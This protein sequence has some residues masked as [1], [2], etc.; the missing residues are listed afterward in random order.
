MNRQT[1]KQLKT[2]EFA[3]ELGQ[4]FSFLKEHRTESI[5]YGLIGL[6]VIVLGAGY[7]FYSR[8]E[9]VVR[10]DAL[11][12]AMKIDDAIVGPADTATNKAFPTK[13]A[14]VQARAKALNDMAT[15]YRGT[16]EGAIAAIFLAADQ[17]D[18]GNYAA[19]EKAYKDVVDSAPK[20]YA[21]LAEVSLADVYSVEGKTEDA[22][23][24]LRYRIDHPTELV[25]S[26]AAKLELA[27]VLASANPTE[28]LKL[29]EPLRSSAHTV[30]SK[31]A[32]NEVARINS[33]AH[34]P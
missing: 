15:K 6:A 24:L 17:V 33:T 22:E 7:Y 11:A 10:E 9:G 19:A 2:D 28:A 16:T 18:A 30:I 12:E 34:K 1:R 3:Q 4:T 29:V 25:S 31:E 23:K 32:I 13:D 20:E 27:D 26:D 5:R 14:K 8:H 21:S